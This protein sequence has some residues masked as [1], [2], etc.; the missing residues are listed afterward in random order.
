[1]FIAPLPQTRLSLTRSPGAMLQK[2]LCGTIF[3]LTLSGSGIGEIGYAL[4][5]A[6]CLGRSGACC[7]RRR[8]SAERLSAW[9]SPVGSGLTD[10]PSPA[11]S[12]RSA[13]REPAKPAVTA[14]VLRKSL[15]F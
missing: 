12:G 8:Y 2:P 3:R 4:A 5:G 1:M 14:L 13:S 15:R 6:G 7:A 10:E 9:I 11:V